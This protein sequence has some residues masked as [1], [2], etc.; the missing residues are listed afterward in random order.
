MGVAAFGNDGSN[1]FRDPAKR[2]S[3]R[4]RIRLL[5]PDEKSGGDLQQNNNASKMR[6]LKQW[7]SQYV[8]V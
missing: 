1:V 6:F 2:K 3:V 4:C 7:I 5:F 8:G